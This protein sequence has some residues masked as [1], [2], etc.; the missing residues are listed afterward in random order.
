MVYH[1]PAGGLCAFAYDRKDLDFQWTA[2]SPNLD[3]LPGITNFQ[4]ITVGVFAKQVEATIQRIPSLQ[5]KKARIEFNF[6]SS[7]AFA[8]A[9]V[10]LSYEDLGFEVRAYKHFLTLLNCVPDFEIA[11]G[12]L[13]G[14]L[15][16][17]N[18]QDRL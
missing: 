15:E 14:I 1:K 18:D 13:A 16:W 4:V 9:T 5:K 6:R 10:W 3:G 2:P 7:V 12:L 11:M 8:S 17:A